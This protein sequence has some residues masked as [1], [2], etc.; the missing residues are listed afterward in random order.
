MTCRYLIV[1]LFLGMI[2]HKM[3]D[4]TDDGVRNRLSCIWIILAV[5]C[6]AP[7]AT[8][9]SWWHRERPIIRRSVRT[10]TVAVWAS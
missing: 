9:V 7:A 3:P 1:A 2:Y 8:I 5:N 6:L 4:T 10:S